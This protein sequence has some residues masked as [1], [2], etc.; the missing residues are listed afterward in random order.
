MTLTL[1]ELVT[2][3]PLVWDERTL[4]KGSQAYVTAHLIQ[5]HCG[6]FILSAKVGGEYTRTQHYLN[7]LEGGIRLDMAAGQFLYRS[8]HRLFKQ[9]TPSTDPDILDKVEYLEYRVRD[10]MAG[11]L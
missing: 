8:P 1:N 11:L 9:I 7:E 10:I 4:H 6:G 2:Y 3:V 5:R